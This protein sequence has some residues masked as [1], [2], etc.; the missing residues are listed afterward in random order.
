MAGCSF[1]LSWLQVPQ[2]F[3]LQVIN[4]ISV[5]LNLHIRLPGEFVSPQKPE[6]EVVGCRR[7]QIQRGG[8]ATGL[9]LGNNFPQTTP[10]CANTDPGIQSFR[11]P[12][13]TS[14]L[15]LTGTPL[16]QNPTCGMSFLKH[17]KAQDLHLPNKHQGHHR[18]VWLSLGLF[19]HFYYTTYCVHVLLGGVGWWEGHTG[20]RIGEAR[21]QLVMG[22]GV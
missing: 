10:N 19:V 6:C 21:G 13:S 1:D 16:K 18:K 20:H 9:R 12:V 11:F 15:L 14:E 5:A 22:G 4:R 7:V 3:I 2:L 17:H 8:N